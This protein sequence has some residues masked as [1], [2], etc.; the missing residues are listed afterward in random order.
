MQSPLAQGGQV[1][2]QAARG[3]CHGARAGAGRP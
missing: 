2:R 1:L 3:L